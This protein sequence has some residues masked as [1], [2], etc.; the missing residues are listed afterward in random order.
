MPSRSGDFVSR[1]DLYK[2]KKEEGSISVQL[3]DMPLGNYWLAV[4][5]LNGEKP[6]RIVSEEG[7]STSLTIYA[8]EALSIVQKIE[9]VSLEYELS[10]EENPTTDESELVTASHYIQYPE[11][12]KGFGKLSH[13]TDKTYLHVIAD[14][15]F[16]GNKAPEQVYVSIR[17]EEQSDH[18]T[19]YTALAHYDE[20]SKR[21]VANL[22]F[23]DMPDQINGS[24]EVRLVALDPTATFTNAS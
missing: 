10:T 21:F 16:T 11:K 3:K 13:G 22:S 2:F 7:V 18:L 1:E 5:Y 19:W 14:I 24:Y 6:K 20:Q 15:K 8:R 9:F 4:D 17:P 12:M 23:S